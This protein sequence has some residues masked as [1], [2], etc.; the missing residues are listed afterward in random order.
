MD[1]PRPEPADREER[2]EKGKREVARVVRHVAETAQDA[3]HRRVEHGAGPVFPEGEIEEGGEDRRAA[4]EHEAEGLQ[5][6]ADGEEGVEGDGDERGGLIEHLPDDQE[7]H[8]RDDGD[9]ELHGEP[10]R[11]DAR[12]EEG[13]E[14][15]LQ[16]EEGLRELP[17]PLPFLRDVA[18]E[19]RAGEIMCGG[20]VARDEFV[21]VQ[22]AGVEVG[23]A[24]ENRRQGDAEEERRRGE[25]PFS[26]G[27]SGA[28]VGG[29]REGEERQ[30]PG[31]RQPGR[32]LAAGD[33]EGHSQADRER[34]AEQGCSGPGR[35]HR[36]LRP[37][38]SAVRRRPGR[39]EVHRGLLTADLREAT[40]ASRRRDGSSRGPRRSGVRRSRA[41]CPWAAWNPSPASRSA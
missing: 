34:T 31:D 8:H 9:V 16:E 6:H 36:R 17:L 7:E 3:R 27:R 13:E 10:H 29:Q 25:L 40:P 39:A 26:P 37:A 5:V 24:H 11:Q 14:S 33:E 2:Q 21:L 22:P 18:E 20:E 28:V 30:E 35:A 32:D 23:D 1:S 15:S 4:D 38:S 19:V 12:S 41:R